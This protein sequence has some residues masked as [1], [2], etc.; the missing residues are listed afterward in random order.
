LVYLLY[1]AKI[2]PDPAIKLG[3]FLTLITEGIFS[4][5]L[6]F[7]VALSI[8]LVFDEHFQDVVNSFCPILQKTE[9]QNFDIAQAVI[10]RLKEE[11]YNIPDD[12]KLISTSWDTG[13]EKFNLVM[14]WVVSVYSDAGRKGS[15]D[16]NTKSKASRVLKKITVS[17]SPLGDVLDTVISQEK[18]S[19]DS[20]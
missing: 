19:D 11:P 6:S 2:L 12:A 17:T 7:G 14:E 16:E 13:E 15:P 8:L 18:Q 5:S 3:A 10:S 20:K 1:I 4:A 9:L